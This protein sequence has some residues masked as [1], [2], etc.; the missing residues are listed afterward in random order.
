MATRKPRDGFA[1]GEL[2]GWW[3]QNW[4]LMTGSPQGWLNLTTLQAIRRGQDSRRYVKAL[5]FGLVSASVHCR[6][7]K[8]AHR[9]RLAR[10]VAAVHQS[11]STLML[12]WRRAGRQGALLCRLWVLVT[13]SPSALA[14]L[15]TQFSPRLPRPPQSKGSSGL[16]LGGSGLASSLARGADEVEPAGLGAWEPRS[17]F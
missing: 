1:G 3:T 7:G 8:G 4:I 14:L 9:A 13:C 5:V 15:G 12:G 6:G 10:P 11:C 2:G 17:S 16:R